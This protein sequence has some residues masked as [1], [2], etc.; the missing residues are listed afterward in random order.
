VDASQYAV[1]AILY[2]CDDEGRQFPMAYHSE[3]LDK[4]QRGWEI[5]NRELYTIVAGLENWHH[6]LLGA[7]HEV[8]VFTDHINLQYYRHPHKINQW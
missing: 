6:L 5:Y 7:K 1:G 3:T 8:L 4:T 2:Q